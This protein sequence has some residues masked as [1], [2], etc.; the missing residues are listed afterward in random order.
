MNAG[1][2]GARNVGKSTVFRALTGLPQVPAH[3]GHKGRARA[4]QIKVPDPRLDFLAALYDSE[5]KIQAEINLFDFA[6]NPK[7]QNGDAALDVSLLPLIRDLDALLIVIARFG[8]MSAEVERSIRDINAELVFADL[9]QAER[10]LERLGKEGRRGDFERATLEKCLAW[11]SS[12]RPLR[13]FSLTAQEAKA[14]SSFGFVSQKPAL[15]VVNQEAKGGREDVLLSGDESA[16]AHGLEL[17]ALDALL[18]AE[19]WELD[20]PQQLDLL[21]AAG[22]EL[23]AGARL[24]RALYHRLGLITFY[25]AGPSEARAW[26]LPQGATALEAAGRV[27]SDIARGFIRAEVISFNDLERLGSETKVREAGRLR[28]ESRDYVIQDG[29]IIHVRFKA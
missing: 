12:G 21:K 8:V 13:T 18:E 28:L 2:I 17:F 4:G 24:V 1:I 27:H 20:P 10:R 16:E 25:T 15:A 6:P 7:E 3:G 26:S 14:I 22:L 23:P 11:L 29:D 19:L 5:K 9:D